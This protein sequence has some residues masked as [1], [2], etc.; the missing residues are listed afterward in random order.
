MNAERLQAAKPRFEPGRAEQTLA[1]KSS[2]CCSFELGTVTST[3]AATSSQTK[4]TL[5]INWSLPLAAHILITSRVR[6]PTIK[7]P[8]NQGPWEAR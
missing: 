6:H 7:A 5:H 1:P 8:S 4:A 2:V 3:Q